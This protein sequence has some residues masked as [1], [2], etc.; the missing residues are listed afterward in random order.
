MSKKENIL[1]KALRFFFNTVK[2]VKLCISIYFE[3]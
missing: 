1:S 3:D 2:T